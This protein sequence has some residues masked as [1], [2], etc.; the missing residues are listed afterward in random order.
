MSVQVNESGPDGPDASVCAFRAV[1]APIPHGGCWPRGRVARKFP[2][3]SVPMVET[4]RPALYRLL[5]IEELTIAGSPDRCPCIVQRVRA[6]T[7]RLALGPQ[8]PTCTR[9]A[10]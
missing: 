3:G 10:V 5:R 7:D 8:A 6:G 9:D 1:D 2:Q 4:R